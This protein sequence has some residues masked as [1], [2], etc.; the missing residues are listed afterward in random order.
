MTNFTFNHE[1]FEKKFKEMEE[2]HERFAKECEEKQSRIR[3]EM[4]QHQQMFNDVMTATSGGRKRPENSSELASQII[5][6]L[7]QIHR[8]SSYYQNNK[9]VE[10]K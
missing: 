6:C 2:E 5:E 7:Q 9:K 3:S 1:E 10:A 4:E 8:P